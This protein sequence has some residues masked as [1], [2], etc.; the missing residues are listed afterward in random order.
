MM[1]PLRRAF[2]AIAIL[3]TVSL[4]GA[5]PATILLGATNARADQAADAAAS[6]IFIHTLADKALVLVNAKDMKDSDRASGFKTLFVEAFDIPDI[7]RF[8]LGRHWKS[9]TPEQQKDFLGAFEDYTV[10][11]WSTRFKDYT[12]VS[13]VVEG[14]TPADD[15]FMIVESRIVRSQGDPLQVGWRV[16]Q[17]AGAWRITD[18][19]IENVS[20]ALTQRQDFAASIQSSGGSVESLLATMHKK[21]DELRANAKS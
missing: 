21:I 18:I 20:M 4:L 12:G 9:A 16:H 14:A 8:V 5:A 19:L 11:T 2:A 10:L 17:V 15:G 3:A 1:E 7:G 13:F 6:Q